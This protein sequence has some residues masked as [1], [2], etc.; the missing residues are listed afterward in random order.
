VAP[1]ASPDKIFSVEPF[2]RL[3]RSKVKLSTL[4]VYC[5]PCYSLTGRFYICRG[6]TAHLIQKAE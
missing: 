5:Y 3:L 4:P 1:E 2:P 6:N